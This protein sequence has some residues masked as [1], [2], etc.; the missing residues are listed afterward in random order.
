[1]N[2]KKTPTQIC[3][4]TSVHPATDIR[5]FYK[6]CQSLAKAGYNVSLIA[7]QE[8]NQKKI[9]CKTEEISPLVS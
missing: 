9:Q 7:P 2:S 1:M 6:E 5:I 4:M 8:K 3:H